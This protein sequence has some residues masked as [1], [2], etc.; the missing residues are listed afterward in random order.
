MITRPIIRGIYEKK[1]SGEPSLHTIV[2][3]DSFSIKGREALLQNTANKILEQIPNKDQIIWININSGLIFK[4]MKEDLPSINNFVKTTYLSGSLTNIIPIINENINTSFTSYELYILSDSQQEM[5]SS[6][7]ENAYH[8]KLFNI[9]LL[10]ASSL[11]NN[12]SISGLNILNEILLPNEIIDINVVVN[13]N[14]NTFEENKLL[15]LIIN[16]MIVGQ[17]LISLKPGT[18]KTFNFKTTLSQSGLH[19]GIVELDKDD[20]EE[21]N[22]FYF[23]I[24]IP[25]KQKVALIGTSTNDMY[26]LKESLNSLN[27]FDESMIISEY[28]SLN[29]KKLNI[30]EKDVIFIFNLQDLN[31][32]SDSMIDEYLYNGGHIILFPNSI[33]S[34]YSG[35]NNI[36]DISDKYNNLS[37]YSFSSD[38]FQEM[39]MNSIEL[40]NVNKIFSEQ[41]GQDRNIKFFQY[42]S[43]PFHPEFTKIQL[44]DGSSIWNRYKIQ[45]GVVDIFGFAI[46]LNWTNFPIKG[47]FL[48]FIHY[49][50]YSNSAS[51]DNLFHTTGEKLKH[52]LSEYYMNTIYH[53]Q[54]NGK[55]YIL[56]PDLNNTLT[57]DILNQPG[58][59]RLESDNYTIYK[60][61]VNISKN[62]LQSHALNINDTRNSLPNDINIIPMNSDFISNI[63]QAR[64]G[65]ELWRYFLYASILLLILEM[66]LSNAKKHT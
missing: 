2:F 19:L 52:T 51:T 44:N 20:R 35:I 13:N 53:L 66:I 22:K 18:G 12:Y 29:D 62:E 30:F 41:D 26:Y 40:N 31:T 57:V 65:I 58:Y 39:E 7:Q 46:N 43:L 56:I 27:K 63:K 17:Q 36:I 54:P 14:G 15:Q 45:T 5:I 33:S 9:H 28:I 34:T 11:D 24:N 48:P 10:I 42:I 49:L 4:G 60:T 61:A 23:I 3:D 59:H 32:V 38:A 37:K 21:D 55:K 6:I 50:L 16:D 64:I 1:L 25:V 47:T 8:L